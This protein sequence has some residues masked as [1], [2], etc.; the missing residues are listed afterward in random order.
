[1]QSGAI[2]DTY[3]RPNINWNV[4]KDV[5]LQTSLFYEHGTEGGGQQASLLEKNYDSYGGGLSL[6]YSPM[7]KSH[8]QR[9]L[10]VN[11]EVFRCSV[12][13]IHAKHGWTGRL[14]YTP[15]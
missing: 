11:P 14:P 13:G 7:K 1:V 2:E 4:I 5:T 12:A 10:P 9:Q 15:K 6:S 3:V 8:D